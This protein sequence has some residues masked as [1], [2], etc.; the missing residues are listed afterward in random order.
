MSNNEDQNQFALMGTGF[1]IGNFDPSSIQEDEVILMGIAMDVSP[2]VGGF[3]TELNQAFGSLVEELQQ[4][5]VADKILVKIVEFSEKIYDKT[6]FMPIKQIDPKAFIFKAKDSGTS[7]FAAAKNIIDSTVT[8]RTQLEATGINV[9]TLV[10]IITDGDD[11]A[12]LGEYKVKASDVAATLDDIAKEE[13]NVFSF[14]TIQFGIGSNKSTFEK[15]QKEMHIKHL[16]VVGQ[17]GKEIRKMV[18]F[19]SASVSKSSSNQPITF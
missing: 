6:G 5:H 1:N 9:K 15:S 19:I 12:S 13:R 8:Y 10:F 3:E 18:G 16:A 14:E 11:N 4:S 7:L 17:T 2:S